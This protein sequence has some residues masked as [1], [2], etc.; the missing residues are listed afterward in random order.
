MVKIV[1]IG[2]ILGPLALASA[3]NGLVDCGRLAAA[4]GIVWFH[5]QAP[6]TRVAYAALPF[7]LVLLAMPSRAG[8]HDRA[9]RL[10]VPF[11]Q[12]SVVYACHMFLTGTSVH[13]WFLP[14]ALLV[15][16]A[17]PVLRRPFVAPA[18][19]L[20]AALALS[21]AGSPDQVPLAQWSFGII[22]VLVGFSYFASGLPVA[23]FALVMCCLV[24]AIFRP[25]SDNITILAGTALALCVLSFRI[26]PDR[27]SG[28]CASLS[29]L[30]YL[31]HPLVIVAGRTIALSG[32]EL[33]AFSI[34]GSLVAAVALETSQRAVSSR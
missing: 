14:F 32:H 31:A 3:R 26:A 28:W 10:L 17:S 4:L 1:K 34:L 33:A 29:M 12:W 7:F 11:L 30:V 18:T 9:R 24:L 19:A 13:L 21:F 22:P 8:L 20:L 25:S 5:T 16:L 2:P 15:S 23:S 6:G 27:I